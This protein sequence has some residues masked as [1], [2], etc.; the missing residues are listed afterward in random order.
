MATM[1]LFKASNICPVNCQNT[2]KEKYLGKQQ[3]NRAGYER[4]KTVAGLVAKRKKA[5]RT[6][7]EELI[8]ETP[9]NNLDY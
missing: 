7:S 5:R 9:G 8:D 2:K 3:H 1:I 4:N 6:D